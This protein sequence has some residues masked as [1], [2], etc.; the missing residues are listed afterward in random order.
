MDEQI[1]LGMETGI[2][3]NLDILAVEAH[4]V[5]ERKIPAP[6]GRGGAGQLSEIRPLNSGFSRP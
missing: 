2:G 6:P 1:I 4:R 5:T 3:E